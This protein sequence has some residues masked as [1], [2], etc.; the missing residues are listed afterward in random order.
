MKRSIKFF[1]FCLLA[2]LCTTTVAFNSYGQSTTSDKGV[3]ING[4]KWATR[5]VAAPGTFAATPESFGTYYQWCDP[6]PQGWRLPNNEEINKL[7][8]TDKVT[9]VWISQNGV[10]GR[11]FTDKTS[12]NS[13]FFPAM[14]FRL[15]SDPN[16]NLHW[17]G[18]RSYYWGSVPFDS[19]YVHALY[20]S[21]D[22]AVLT[23]FG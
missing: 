15:Y 17:V 10:N 21:D 18:S 13:V 19:D 3:V 8:D 23:S 5:N 22:A 12:G 2:V 1:S 16:N 7:L 9:S 20:F 4:V 14:G 11:R 6:S